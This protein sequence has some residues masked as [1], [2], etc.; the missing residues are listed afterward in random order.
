MQELIIKNKIFTTSP[1][2]LFVRK[3]GGTISGVKVGGTSMPFM[4]LAINHIAN[5]NCS[6]FNLP[7]C[8]ISHKA[9]QKY[10]N[11]IKRTVRFFFPPTYFTKYGPKLVEVARIARKRP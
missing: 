11:K 8:F 10:V 7:L 3:L 2:G 9:L 6:L 1:S 5:A 4:Y